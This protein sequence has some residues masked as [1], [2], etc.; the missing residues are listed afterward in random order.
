[1][2]VKC[3][4][5]LMEGTMAV[6]TRKERIDIRISL[7][8][9]KT[10][11]KAA[12]YNNLSLSSYIISVVLKQAKIDLMDNEIIILNNNERDLF[13]KALNECNEP[14]QALKDLFK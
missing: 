6:T 4:Y 5:T 13:I 1:M 11:E 12:E 14:N 7:E 9:K 3:V 2:C 8:D 10:L